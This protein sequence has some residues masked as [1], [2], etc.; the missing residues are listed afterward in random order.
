HRDL[1]KSH[2][3][4]VPETAVLLAEVPEAETVQVMPMSGVAERAEVRI[5]R[6]LQTHRAAG[7]DQ[8]MEL[9]HGADHVVDMFDDVDRGQPIEGTVREGIGKAIEIGEYVGAAVGIPVQPDAAG[10]LVNPAADVE[11]FQAVRTASL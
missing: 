3:C 1:A 7:A 2:P 8:A 10:L 6:G 9:L 4:I 5:M 11:Y